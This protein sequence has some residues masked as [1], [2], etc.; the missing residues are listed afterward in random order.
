M[1]TLL[2]KSGAAETMAASILKI[3]GEKY[4][5]LGMAI[6]GYFVSIPVYCDSAYVLLS[7][8]ARRLSRDTKVSM[9][10]M[11]VALAMGLHATHMLVPPTPGPLAVAGILGADLSVVICVGMAVSIP[12]VLVALLI[13]SIMGKKY[14]YLPT[15]AEEPN[16]SK[17]VVL[18]RPAEAFVPIILPIVLMLLRTIVSFESAPLGRGFLYQL[19]FSLGNTIVALMIGLAFAFITYRRLFPEDKQMWTFE[20]EF[21]E[22]LKTAGQ[23]V[24]IVGAGGAFAA[25]LELS[26][27]ENMVKETFS[28]IQAGI[29]VPFAIGAIFRTAVGA[30]TVG[31]ITSAS[32][33]LPLLDVLGFASPVGRLVAMLAC[34]AGGFFVFHGNDNYFWVIT[35]TSEMPPSVAYKVFPLISVLQG[36]T[37]LICAYALSIF[38]M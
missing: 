4:A 34:A 17:K 25:V 13:G 2:E 33:L 3:T 16:D 31:M 10:T 29:L 11:A 24:M 32:M 9:T 26:G 18:P 28:G 12:V 14:Y 21:G 22:A 37:A 38:L 35:S 30:G 19:F 15:F 8:L 23:I 5:A 36:F 7:P 27:L 6:T 20:G 1:G